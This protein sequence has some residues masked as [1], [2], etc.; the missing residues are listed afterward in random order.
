[1]HRIAFA[2]ATGF[3]VYLLYPLRSHLWR[4]LHSAIY[5]RLMLCI[6]IDAAINSCRAF[7]SMYFP[8]ASIQCSFGIARQVLLKC[9][10]PPYLISL[11]IL[12]IV[13]LF[14]TFIYNYIILF[15]NSIIYY[16]ISIISSILL[17]YEYFFEQLPK[18]N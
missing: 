1:M 9:T 2:I 10:V 6:E 7:Q 14:L 11:C 8:R 17:L 16:F 13:L 4:V 12:S 15:M 3:A 5:K 18:H